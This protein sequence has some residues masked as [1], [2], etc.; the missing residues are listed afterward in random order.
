M[1]QQLSGQQNA[2]IRARKDEEDRRRF[3][4]TLLGE[5]GAGVIR[6]DRDERITLANRSACEILGLEE[7]PEGALL[8]DVAP[9]FERIV[10]D[11]F[12]R[13]AAV[14]AGLDRTYLAR[15]ESGLSVLLLDRAI[16][17]LRLLGAEISIQMPDRPHAP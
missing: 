13:N 3:V 9:I 6:V 2:L 4:E 7:V 1:T 15:M 16:R 17:L 12:E 10:R 5:L 11:T 14:D 8:A